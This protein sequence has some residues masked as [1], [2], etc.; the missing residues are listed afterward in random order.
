MVDIGHVVAERA[1]SKLEPKRVEMRRQSESSGLKSATTTMINSRANGRKKVVCV[2]RFLNREANTTFFY[3]KL[4]DDFFYGKLTNTWPM[5][6]SPG[7][8]L[9]IR[10]DSIR[11]SRSALLVGSI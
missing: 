5:L 6:Q 1:N 7:A 2:S 11:H 3:G 4:A 8:G 10:F 9:G